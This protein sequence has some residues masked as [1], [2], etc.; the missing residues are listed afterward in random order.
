MGRLVLPRQLLFMLFVPRVR[1]KKFEPSASP[2]YG[3]TYTVIKTPKRVYLAYSART[4]EAVFVNFSH[5]RRQNRPR[6][7]RFSHREA[8]DT[9]VLWLNS[10]PLSLPLNNITRLV[11]LQQYPP[12]QQSFYRLS[13]CFEV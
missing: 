1:L 8:C 7:L 6:Q 12:A 13:S 2:L 9:P 11:C 3:P 4:D 5:S 10:Q